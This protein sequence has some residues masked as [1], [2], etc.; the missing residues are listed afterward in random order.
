M[1][2]SYTTAQAK[3]VKKYLENLDEIKTRTPKGKKEEYRTFVK[4]TYG[5]T[6]SFNQF[7][8]DAIEEKIAR[9]TK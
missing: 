9:E 4:N 3:A 2:S 7:V 1:S 8:I 5:S 6:L